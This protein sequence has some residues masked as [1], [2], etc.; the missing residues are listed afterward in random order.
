MARMISGGQMCTSRKILCHARLFAR[1]TQT[2]QQRS[3]GNP[4]FSQKIFT[5]LVWSAAASFILSLPKGRRFCG[6]CNLRDK[7]FGPAGVQ[8][9]FCVSARLKTRADLTQQF[10]GFSPWG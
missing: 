4:Y 5:A 1:N 2:R 9:Y 7:R 10:K 3:T 6:V 8:P